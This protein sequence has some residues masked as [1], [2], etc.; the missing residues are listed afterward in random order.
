[1]PKFVVQEHDART[2]HFD[3]RLEKEGVFKS[4]A[5]PKGIPEKPG[6]KR[7]AVQ[8]EDHDLAYGDFEGTLPEGQYGAGKVRIWDKGT[9]DSEEWN[10]NVIVFNLHGA[11]ASGRFNL[12]RFKHGKPNEW[13]IIKRSPNPKKA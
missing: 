4:W 8:V 3:F 1:M 2:H 11:L 5:V 6:I 12:V 10:D 7:L 13:L 9:Y